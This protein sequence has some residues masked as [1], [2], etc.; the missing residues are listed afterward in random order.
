MDGNTL[1]VGLE[2][3]KLPSA[4]SFVRRRHWFRVRSLKTE[5]IRTLEET[6]RT[7]VELELDDLCEEFELLDFSPTANNARPMSPDVPR[8]EIQVSLPDIPKVSIL[9]K[10]NSDLGSIESE[11]SPI[12]PLK[13]ILSTSS[14]TQD[15]LSLTD[16]EADMEISQETHPVIN[17]DIIEN[18]TSS[19]DLSIDDEIVIERH[20][21]VDEESDQE[22]ID[23]SVLWDKEQERH[24]QQ[25]EESARLIAE[26]EKQAEQSRK[27][28]EKERLRL[29]NEWKE[30]ELQV[31]KQMEDD[32]KRLEALLSEEFLDSVKKPQEI[33]QDTST[34]APKQIE[35]QSPKISSENAPVPIYDE[36]V[37]EDSEIEFE[38][39]SDSDEE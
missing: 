30:K 23:A 32:R 8:K 18:Q 36:P 10:E 25:L 31:K 6:S 21:L 34:A 33:Q 38:P 5:E 29:E 17:P 27:A 20:D 16:S 26:R 12:I 9:K 4:T 24:K 35:P 15:E 3:G 28:R 14:I 1:V 11:D 7:D 39:V 2:I 37:G 19:L 22:N 13:R